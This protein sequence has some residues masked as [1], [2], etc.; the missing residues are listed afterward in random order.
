MVRSNRNGKKLPLGRST[1]F[2]RRLIANK[3]HNITYSFCEETVNNATWPRVGIVVSGTL[4]LLMFSL[5]RIRANLF[6]VWTQSMK[7]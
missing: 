4:S 7:K 2:G 6:S 3:N 5:R 1:R